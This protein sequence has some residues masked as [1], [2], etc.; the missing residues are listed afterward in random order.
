MKRIF[1]KIVDVKPDE[2][3]AL[4]L[5]FVFNFMVLGGYYVIRPIRDEI[6]ASSGVENLPW[7][8]TATLVAMLVANALFSALVA[9]M[10]RR[11][12]IPIAYRFF[13]ANLVI[14]SVLMRVLTPAQ[15][16]WLGKT[17]FVWLSVANLFVV[18]VFWAFMTDLFS[19]DQGKRLFGFIS[20]GGSLGAIIGGSITAWLVK[21]IGPANLLLVSGV[22]FEVA[23]Q[24]VRFFPADFARGQQTSQD[25][26]AE[27][28]AIGGNLWSGITHIFRSPYLF[29]L[30]AFIIFYSTTST[31]AYFQQSDLAGHGFA[32][33]A[34]RTT[35]FANLDRSVNTLTLL[36]QLFLTG[37]LLKWLGVTPT[38]IIMPAL[39]LIGFVFIGV[40][41]LLAVLAVF[42]VLR[43]AATFAFMRPAREVLFTVLRREDKYKA[44]SVI[45]TFA[46]RVGDQLG[47][48]SYRGLNA[49]GFGLRGIS[50]ITI[51]II[52]AWLA[53][54]VWL[55][56]KQR[57]FAEAQR[58]KRVA[59]SGD[60][61]APEAA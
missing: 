24:S 2:I 14:F 41:P 22:M 10:S 34:A 28:A 3:R 61:A 15:Q 31:W 12:F 60:I 44:K 55:G 46:Y 4:W 43:R 54:S 16:V 51:P 52:A 23:A 39:S 33:R 38:L 20:I 13:I 37:R 42:Q 1:S 56:H 30:F 21:P 29:G 47:A 50:F 19:N 17:F 11:K 25:R 8:F 9:G 57:I 49:F 26:R 7:M 5:G 45:D 40:S 35:F 36:G 58:G 59:P 18:T 27:D 6:G 32:D 53:L 48:W